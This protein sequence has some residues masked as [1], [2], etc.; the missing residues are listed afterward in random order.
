[1][2]L[3][4]ISK[5]RMLIKTVL[6]RKC[7]ISMIINIMSLFH[8]FLFCSGKL[9]RVLPK[10]IYGC[11]KLNNLFLQDLQ[12]FLDES[13]EGVIYFS[14]GS[15]LHSSNMKNA[16]TK[17]FLEAFSQLKQK[18]LWKWETDSLPGQPSNV[19]LGKWLPQSDILG[20]FVQFIC[21]YRPHTSIFPNSETFMHVPKLIA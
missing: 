19:K 8:V 1:M 17:A 21:K 4:H 3:Y 11:Q 16:T 13:P 5:R 18:V 14:M 6:E 20:E 10:T 12:R 9:K 2:L 15:I 7:I